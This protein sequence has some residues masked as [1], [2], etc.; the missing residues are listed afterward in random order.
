MRV[1]IVGGI[2]GASKEEQARR[3]L[4]P[5]TILVENLRQRGLEVVPVSHAAFRPTPD[6]D[7]IHIHHL[8]QAALRMAAA[9]TQTPF[10]FTSH[11]PRIFCGYEKSVVRK[12]AFRYVLAKADVTVALSQIE[13]EF[14]RKLSG[15]REIQV[16][17]NGLPADIFYPDARLSANGRYQLLYVG[18]LVE[19]KGVNVL[20][21]AFRH[22]R[23]KWEASLL[24][25][26]QNA[27]LE[28]R[29]QQQVKDLGLT[30]YV[31][32]VG[33]LS[34]PELAAMYRRV[35]LLVHPSFAEAMPSIITEAMFSGLP[36][37]AT[38]VGG[39]PEQVGR[40]GKLVQPGNVA[41]LA[42]AIDSVLAELPRFRAQAQ[43]V[44]EYSRRKFGLENMVNT[45]LH[46]YRGLVTGTRD[47]KSF[48]ALD[49]LLHLAARM[50]FQ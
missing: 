25:V 27:Q 23:Q 20:L 2:F 5:E 21:E 3:L 49:R 7:I 31:Q 39:V 36:V 24:L 14:L 11:N 42:A 16:I 44:S 32:F 41:E 26:Y 15:G 19:F 50:Y 30:G 47:N 35:D 46:L 33:R 9:R 37:V 18:Q 29:Y 4:T 38:R 22:I 1:C 45:H 10:V 40:Y 43:E 34:S 12:L 28:R 6:F 8:G 17:P 48:G 13:A